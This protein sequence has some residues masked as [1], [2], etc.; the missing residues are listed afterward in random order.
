M[1]GFIVDASVA[2]KWLVAEPGAHLATPLLDHPLAAP[3]LLGPECANILWKKVM[4]GELSVPE[5]ET[6]AAA[7]ESADVALH[8]TRPLWRAA[9]AAAAALRHPAYDCI[10][11]CLAEMLARPLVTADAR[12]VDVV[13]RSSPARFA[14]LVVPLPELPPALAAPPGRPP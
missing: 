8:A 1:S 5:A 7:L 2:I 13:R 12:L 10:Y 4:R 3:D 11:L 14:D 9:V 6:M